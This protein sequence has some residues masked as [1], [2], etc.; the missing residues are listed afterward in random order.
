MIPARVRRPRDKAKAESAV[1]VAE[2]WIMPASRNH[3]FFS[4][5]ELNR[6]IAQKLKELNRRK[7]QKMGYV[8]F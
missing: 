3:R 8:V 7:F 2:R 1:F 4:L 6:A 5:A